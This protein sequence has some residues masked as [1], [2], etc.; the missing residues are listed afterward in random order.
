[1]F[2]NTFATI[3]IAVSAFGAPLADAPAPTDQRIDVTDSCQKFTENWSLVPCSFYDETDYD[4]D[5][6]VD[7]TGKPI[8]GA[9]LAKLHPPADHADNGYGGEGRYS[10]DTDYNCGRYAVDHGELDKVPYGW[11]VGETVQAYDGTTYVVVEYPDGEL[12]WEP[13]G[14]N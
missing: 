7:Q 6:L 8:N 1:M 11:E 4:R 13:V 3:A 2:S 14:A 12:G 9:I 10:C 5:G